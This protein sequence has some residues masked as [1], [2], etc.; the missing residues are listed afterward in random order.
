M[1]PGYVWNCQLAR[2]LIQPNTLSFREK[3]EQKKCGGLPGKLRLCPVSR[4]SLTRSPM[5]SM[6][7]Y[8]AAKPQATSYLPHHQ[9]LA[10]GPLPPMQ[11][12]GPPP[13]SLAAPPLLVQFSS[14]LTS[15]QQRLNPGASS[16]FFLYSL[17]WR[18]HPVLQL[19]LAIPKY[20]LLA[21]TSLLN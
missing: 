21:R 16:L 4:L 13:T 9:H 1:F 2:V 19:L 7:L 6:L 15:R 5:S 18:R 14:L 17:P 20:I 11:P 12:P 3:D 10:G 8:P